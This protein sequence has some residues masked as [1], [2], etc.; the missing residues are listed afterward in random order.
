MAKTPGRVGAGT[1]VKSMRS[2]PWVVK[3]GPQPGD[4]GSVGGSTAPVGLRGAVMVYCVPRRPFE[5]K[6]WAKRIAGV[7]AQKRPAEKRT[8]VFA[9][10]AQERPS[11]GESWFL[12][13]GIWPF[14]LNEPLGF[15]SFWLRMGSSGLSR[16]S[17][18][19]PAVSV[20]F[21]L[22]NHWSWTNSA[23]SFWPKSARPAWLEVRPPRPPNWRYWFQRPARKSASFEKMKT[24]R[25]LPRK[26]WS[27]EVSLY[28]TPPLAT[29]APTA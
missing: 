29:W 18:R 11:R 13:S 16:F 21:E 12:A 27:I 23:V 7:R 6:S 14:G 10:G 1:L 2:T 15:L 22:R 26:T 8:A 4:S 9:S 28:S 5:V 20:M 3:L 17:K 24:P 25:Q 19:N